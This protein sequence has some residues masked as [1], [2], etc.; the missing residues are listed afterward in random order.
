MSGGS[1][2]LTSAIVTGATGFIGSTLV[3]RLVARGVRVT[4]LVRAGSSRLDRVGGAGITTVA[5]DRFE[6]EPVRAVLRAAGR[7]DAL[8]HLASYGV[9]PGERDPDAMTAG[10]ATLVKTLLSAAADLGL[11]RFV[12]TG[13]CSEYGPASEPALLTETSL[14][15][16][17]SPY[18][19]A[20]LVAE[21]DGGEQAKRLG[22]PLVT[23]RLF[24][25]YGPFE[26]P[27]RLVP[28]LVERL[29][30]GEVPSLTGGEQARDLMFVDDVA[31][32]IIASATSEG[33]TEGEA[34][35]VCTGVPV[36]IRE[37]A[38]EVAELMEKPTADLG[39]G[40]RA[41][42]AD[43]AMW[44]VGDPTRFVE[45]TGLRPRLSRRDGLRRSI[46]H[47]LERAPL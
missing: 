2:Q 7:A 3:R 8:F 1:R 6:P 23:L 31:D 20:K 25:T 38:H 22:V 29:R 14:L 28:Y 37:V 9:D 41:Y 46:A 34:Y 4:C 26:A 45:A 13:S 40:R 33:I 44:I 27:E 42:R 36:R 21:R 15:E 24:G 18:G 10:N 43:E 30:R 16:P 47:C 19:V 32:A 17:T 35:N 11:Q 5:L 12:Y 39:L